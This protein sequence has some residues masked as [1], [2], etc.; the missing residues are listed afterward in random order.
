[1]SEELIGLLDE[2]EDVLTK[3]TRL[4]FVHRLMVDEERATTLLDRLRA[5]V[6]EEVRR[7]RQVL[8]ER[9][10]L[11]EQARRQAQ[12]IGEQ[13]QQEASMRLER[14][15]LLDEAK[16]RT[17]QMVEVARREAASVRQGADDYARKVLTEIETLLAKAQGELRETLGRTLASVR[18]GLSELDEGEDFVAMDEP[19]EEE[20]E[21]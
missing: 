21:E 1:M 10:Q 19:E 18:K 4:P 5:A 13:A 11:L 15:G 2:L 16:S 9:D 17:G 6:P 12:R 20:M 3:S 14:D 7:A 8:R